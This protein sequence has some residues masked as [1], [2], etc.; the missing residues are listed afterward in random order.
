MI[1][2]VSGLVWDSVGW[3]FEPDLS[4]LLSSSINDFARRLFVTV[5]V[6]K[7]DRLG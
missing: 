2:Y 4:R 5:S 7:N 1:L 6:N 3:A